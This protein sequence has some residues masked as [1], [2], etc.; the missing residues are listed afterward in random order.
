M[1][2]Q[3]SRTPTHEEVFKES[4]TLKSDKSKWVDKRSQDT[5]VRYS[6]NVK[7]MYMLPLK[8]LCTHMH[9]CI[10]TTRNA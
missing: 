4:H 3:L 7:L 6:I 5:H 1:K 2:R 9:V 8:Y 10:Y